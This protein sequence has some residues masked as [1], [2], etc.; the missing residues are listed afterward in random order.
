MAHGQMPGKVMLTIAILTWPALL[1]PLAAPVIGGALTEY[2][3]WR[4]IFVLNVPIGL[5]AIVAVL[6]VF[7]R[8]DWPVQ[9]RELD[10][11][12]LAFAAAAGGGIVW[13]LDLAVRGES[14][15]SAACAAALIALWLLAW[16]VTH[17]PGQYSTQLSSAS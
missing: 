6:I 4:W 9:R 16:R 11:P 12:G 15:W 13:A 8:Q 1:A 14:S 17:T 5:L 7:G 2:A 10:W 3:G